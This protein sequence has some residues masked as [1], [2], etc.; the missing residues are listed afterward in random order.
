MDSHVLCCILLVYEKLFLSSHI[1]FDMCCAILL[2]VIRY[3]Y[4]MVF[5]IINLCRSSCYYGSYYS[6]T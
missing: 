2:D 4:V 3:H 5:V 1:R 6:I